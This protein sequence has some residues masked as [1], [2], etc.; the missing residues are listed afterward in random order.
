MDFVELIDVYFVL[1]DAYI[2]GGQLKRAERYLST[3]YT[4]FFKIQEETLKQSKGVL[5]PESTRYTYKD[6]LADTLIR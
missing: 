4:V 2:G 5:S 3:G 6:T 1:A